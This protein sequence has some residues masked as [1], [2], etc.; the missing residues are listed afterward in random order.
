MAKCRIKG[1]R[2]SIG[3]GCDRGLVKSEYVAFGWTLYFKSVRFGFR[4]VTRSKLKY[5]LSN[6][7]LMSL[8]TKHR[9]G[10]KVLV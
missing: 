1:H 10:R 4:F 9:I 7:L 8:H 2:A 5:T 3:Q 6:Y